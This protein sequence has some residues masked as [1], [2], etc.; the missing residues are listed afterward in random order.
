MVRSE[1]AV[2]LPESD[3]ALLALAAIRDLPDADEGLFRTGG[4]LRRVSAEPVLLF[5]G[6]RALLLEVAHP[7]IAAGVAEHSDFRADPFGRLQRTLDAMGAIAFRSRREAFAAARGVERAHRSVS[8]VLAAGTARLPAGTAYDGRD[9]DLMCWVWATLVDTALV[10][11]ERFV[12][13]LPSEAR[14]SYYADQCAIARLLGVPPDRIPPDPSAFA[15]YFRTMLESGVLEVTDQ[16][17]AIA[18]AVLNP[19]GGGAQ[20]RLVST[21]TGALLPD[22]LRV[23]FG[24]AWDERRARRFADLE[25]SVRALRRVASVDGAADSR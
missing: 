24:I 12:S 19:P 17:R 9:P 3:E 22:R 8:G 6:G 14:A 20:A 16:G 15:D 10:V 11:Y 25:R 13:E 2:P 23:A 5:G 4:W 7:L 21:V 1:A 18:D